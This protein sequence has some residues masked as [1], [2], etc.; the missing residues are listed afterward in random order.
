MTITKK[1]KK[2]KE[3]KR[4]AVRPNKSVSRSRYSTKHVDKIIL[5]C[6]AIPTRYS[7]YNTARTIGMCF[8][9]GSVYYKTIYSSRFGGFVKFITLQDFNASIW[10]FSRVIRCRRLVA[11]L[12]DSFVFHRFAVSSN[13]NENRVFSL[14][15]MNYEFFKRSQTVIVKFKKKK[16]WCAKYTHFPF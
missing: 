10:K 8:V 12:Q 16:K 14:S 3:K 2:E 11:K 9:R 15:Y 7:H 6:F 1:K 13:K 5:F 4:Q